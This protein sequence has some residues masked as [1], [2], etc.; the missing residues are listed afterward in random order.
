MAA[1]SFD[2]ARSVR[3]ARSRQPRPNRPNLPNRDGPTIAG[4]G[5]LGRLGQV[6]TAERPRLA[7]EATSIL[8]AFPDISVREE[9][10][11]PDF[12]PHG[13]SIRE[14]PPTWTGRIVSLDEWRRLSD[15]RRNEPNRRN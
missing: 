1:F 15:W 3:E 11:D 7:A 13:I 8:P 2:A 12:F 4:L 6:P 14:W 5:G 10:P 9:V